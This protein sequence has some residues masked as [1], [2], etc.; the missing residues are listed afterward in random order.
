MGPITN[1]PLS[2]DLMNRI[3]INPG[4]SCPAGVIYAKM[5][6]LKGLKWAPPTTQSCRRDHFSF[7]G[8]G[9]L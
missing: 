2:S 8:Y 6:G 9:S 3:C 5:F 1:E 4:Q 7:A